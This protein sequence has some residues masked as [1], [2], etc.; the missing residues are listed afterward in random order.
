MA[1]DR[2]L[3]ECMFLVCDVAVREWHCAS[4][5]LRLRLRNGHVDKLAEIDEEVQAHA[6]SG[7][8]IEA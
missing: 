7:P 2:C 5:T 8:P 6:F 3:V 1:W 4:L